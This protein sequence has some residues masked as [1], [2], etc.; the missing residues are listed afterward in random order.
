MTRSLLLEKGLELFNSQGYAATTVDEIAAA[1][2]TTRT[3][4]YLHFPSKGDL[5]RALVQMADDILTSIDDP[6]LTGV[7]ASNDRKQIRIF[8][9]HKFD[10]WAEIKPYIQASH[11]AAAT[12]PDIQ[13]TID[14][15]FDHAIGDME[16]GLNQAKRFDA[17]SRRVRCELAFGELEFLSR[18]WMR[19]GWT[20]D[21]EAA[22]DTMT[23][24]WC[25]L[26]TDK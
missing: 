14:A 24:S 5:A 20:V 8:L 9:G 25:H 10:Q 13:A 12:E 22:L 26:L 6:T 4:F 3:T 19:L 7:V 11:Q 21:R 23:D 18:R 15:W 17:T 2:G 16:K 1:V